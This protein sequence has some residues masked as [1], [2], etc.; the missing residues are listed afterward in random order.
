[1]RIRKLSWCEE[2]EIYNNLIAYLFLNLEWKM[3]IISYSVRGLFKTY[4]HNIEFSD[5]SRLKILLGQNGIGK[6]AMLKIMN[7]FFSYNIEEI[8]HYYFEQIVFTFDNGQKIVLAHD[9]S[10]VRI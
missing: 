10:D 7:A 6:T 8:Q 2:E 3:K 9:T 5:D 4:N 1:M